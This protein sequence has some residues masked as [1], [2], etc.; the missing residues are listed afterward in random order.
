MGLLDLLTGAAQPQQSGDPMQSIND[1]INNRKS[2]AFY[3]GVLQASQPSPMK[4][5]LGQV[6]GQ[7]VIAQNAA[8]QDL[9]NEMLNTRLKM[10]IPQWKETKDAFGN[11]IAYNALNPKQT[12][13]ISGSNPFG[14]PTNAAAQ[15]A[16]NPTQLT[17]DSYLSTLDPKIATQVKALAEGRMSFPG[18]FALKSPYWQQMVSA[19]SQYDPS[20]DAVNYNARA[21]TR[22]DFTSGKSAQNITSLNTA[23][24]HLGSLAEASDQLGNTDYPM[25]N[26]VKNWAANQMGDPQVKAFNT[27]R[28]AVVDEFTRVFRGTGGNASDIESWKAQLNDANSPAQFKAVMQKGVDLLKSRVDAI[29]DTYNRGMGTTSDPLQLLSQKAQTTLGKIGSGASTA[30]PPAS[31]I[32]YLKANPALA[33]QFEAKYG[34]SASQFLG[35]AGGQ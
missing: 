20:F 4:M 5:G 34:V 23:I 3:S 18:G 9:D 29:G 22:K 11:P 27:N 15:S 2:Q 25:V 31:A 12:Q 10:M 21:S 33:K 6:L 16:S 24:G 30:S 8:S 14:S 1:L 35:G 28:D 19:V 17:G 7:G 13:Q 32:A 26:S